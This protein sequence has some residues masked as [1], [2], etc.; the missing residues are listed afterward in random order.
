[1]VVILRV[2]FFF[3]WEGLHFATTD[4]QPNARIEREARRK[5]REERKER[6]KRRTGN[7][8]ERGMVV[9]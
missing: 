9:L 5:K 1:M 3:D 8:L 2:L 4:E 7:T 6:G